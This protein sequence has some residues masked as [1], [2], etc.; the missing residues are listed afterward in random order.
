[1]SKIEGS[2][3]RD[4][5]KQKL[6]TGAAA[7]NVTV[8][9]IPASARLVSVIQLTDGTD[10]SAE[11]TVSAV[12]TINNTGGTSTATKKLLVTWLAVN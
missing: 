10:L 5:V 9:G 11:F 6:V 7:G 3:S 2:I 8:T 1:M 4:A 12:N